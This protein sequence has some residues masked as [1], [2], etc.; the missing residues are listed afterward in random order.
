MRALLTALAIALTG[1]SCQVYKEVSVH[2]VQKVEVSSF[3]A[4]GLDVMVWLDI[5]N[6]NWYGIRLKESDVEIFLEGKSLGTVQLTST[7]SVPKKSR[8][9]QPMSFHSPITSID[10]LLGNVFSLLFKQKFEVTGK[11]YVTGKAFF[12]VRRVDAAFRYE[13]TR[14]HLGL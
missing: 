13:I 7:V 12:V 4:D 3:T 2:G 1:T 6:P 5:E 8:S 11:G 9:V 10:Q 14:E